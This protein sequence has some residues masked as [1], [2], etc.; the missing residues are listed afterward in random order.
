MLCECTCVRSFRR[1]R[2]TYMRTILFLGMISTTVKW[3]CIY[4]Q[5]PDLANCFGIVKNDFV[6]IARAE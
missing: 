5:M 3:Y 2:A 6:F 1:G 4:M